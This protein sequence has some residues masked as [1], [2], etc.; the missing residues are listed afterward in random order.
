MSILS[1]HELGYLTRKLKRRP[2]SVEAD[3]IGVEWSEHCSYKSSKKYL[4]LLPTRGP[5]VIIG[6]GQDA[7]ALDV[8]D[9]Y[10][11]SVHI[12]SHNH[13][14]AIEPYGGAATGVGGVIRDI[15]SIGTR[16]IAILD[17]LRFGP[18]MD[19]NTSANSKSKSKWLLKNV[20]SGIGDYGNCIGVPTIGGE[21]EFDS[22]F[23]DYCLVDVA[24]IGIARKDHIVTSKA[25]VDDLI[26]LAGGST[27]RD[28]I[29]GASFASAVLNDEDNRSAVQ[30]PDPF[31]EKLLLEATMEAV[32]HGCI[33]AMKD[34]GGGGLACCLSET[35]DNLGK[36]FEIE[37]DNVHI[38]HHDMSPA[39]IMISESQERMLYV[40]DTSKLQQLISIFDK[41]EI[42]H[43]IIGRVKDGS[44]VEIRFRGK[45]VASIPSS[46]FAH[47]PLLS[48]VAKRPEYLGILNKNINKKKKKKN[49]S[50]KTSF[51]HE[52]SHTD[53]S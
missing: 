15:I 49:K 10:V 32:E 12:E 20:V 23:E 53:A 40:T 51:Y 37:L 29:H 22:S 17:A 7:A 14:S 41:Y 26:I 44:T 24:S 13:P 2:N 11:I 8:G 4:R 30:I 21:V 6:A 36:R 31:L 46:I 42:R 9:G 38:K 25:D 16:P 18:I 1:N 50:N 52:S 33:K 3:I 45:I 19:P 28:G 47:A 35:S 27:G 34:L 5:R 39:E 43:A 48:R